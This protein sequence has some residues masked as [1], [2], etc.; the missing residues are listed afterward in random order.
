MT[1]F[2]MAS[3]AR[4]PTVRVIQASQSSMLVSGCWAFWMPRSQCRPHRQGRG[5]VALRDRCVP[6]AVGV[7]M[8]DQPA[9]ARFDEGSVELCIDP[10]PGPRSLWRWTAR[11]WTARLPN[12]PVRSSAKADRRGC[13]LWLDR[14]ARTCSRMNL[15][16]RGR[17]GRRRAAAFLVIGT[18]TAAGIGE[19]FVLGWQEAF[20]AC[21]APWPSCKPPWGSRDRRAACPRWI[22]P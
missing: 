2:A 16:C 4:E 3:G 20:E 11:C 15:T 6:A 9:R 5:Q 8:L 7:L 12:D 18:A 10:R 1:A 14:D 17:A 19:G 13:E 21:S 22:R